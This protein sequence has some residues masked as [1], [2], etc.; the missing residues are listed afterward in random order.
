MVV[1]TGVSDTTRIADFVWSSAVA[2]TDVGV[3]IDC[4]NSF[5][6]AESITSQFP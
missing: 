5:G 3:A 1:S 2:S 4:C 6:T